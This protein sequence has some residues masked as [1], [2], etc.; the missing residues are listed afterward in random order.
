ME[1]GGKEWFQV[2]GSFL[3][4]CILIVLSFELDIFWDG[5]LSVGLG[6]LE[7]FH[8]YASAARFFPAY[9][10]SAGVYF[11]VACITAFLTNDKWGRIRETESVRFRYNFIVIPS[12]K[13][14]IL[15]RCPYYRYL[16]YCFSMPR[17][18]E[19]IYTILLESAAVS[20]F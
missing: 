11:V 12:F 3:E 5:N 1:T 16:F 7:A 14:I 9:L 6:E 13:N 10:E 18:G 17:N 8:S 19:N 20:F 2:T 15:H 4:Y